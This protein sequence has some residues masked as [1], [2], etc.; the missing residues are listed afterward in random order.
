MAD[1]DM[2]PWCSLAVLAGRTFL[3]RAMTQR[4][5]TNPPNEHGL[6][7]RLFVTASGGL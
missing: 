6:Y 1:G 3:D 2:I 4:V 5:E 7:L